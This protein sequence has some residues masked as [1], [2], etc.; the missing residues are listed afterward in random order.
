MIY[1][2]VEIG[3]A[4]A[5]AG[6]SATVLQ[7]FITPYALQRYDHFK[8]YYFFTRCYFWAFLSMPLLHIVAKATSKP[9][10]TSPALW[11]AIAVVIAFSKVACL[12][13]GYVISISNFETSPMR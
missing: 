1:Q 9:G 13:Y 4:L 3:Y 11:I 6:F 10:A 8:L 5:I 2:I 12:A 7:I